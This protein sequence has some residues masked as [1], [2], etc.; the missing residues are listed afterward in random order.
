MR[1]SLGLPERSGGE[2]I[3]ANLDVTLRRAGITLVVV[4]TGF[5]FLWRLLTWLDS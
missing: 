3:S 5:L 2:P 4:G 1:A